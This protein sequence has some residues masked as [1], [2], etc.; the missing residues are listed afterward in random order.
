M[1]RIKHPASWIRPL[2]GFHWPYHL[3]HFEVP[4]TLRA[5]RCST[6][7]I[8]PLGEPKV[9]FVATAKADLNCPPF[10]RSAPQRTGLP[11]LWLR[12]SRHG[13]RG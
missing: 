9:N 5:P 12:S 13:L 4:N 6:S 10:L 1:K 8:S 7:P 3:C 2:Y 11:F